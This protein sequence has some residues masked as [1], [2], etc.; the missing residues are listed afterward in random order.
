ML[1]S[2]ATSNEEEDVT[3]EAAAQGATKSSDGDVAAQVL[4]ALRSALGDER[5]GPD[6][7]FF[8]EGGDSVA[9]VQALQLIHQ[10]T[11]VQLAVAVFFT[12]A[13][14]GQLAEL[15]TGAGAAAGETAA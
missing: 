6:D 4:S 15:V 9:A 1:S 14:A 12:H 3:N 13:S 8:A 10:T 5:L 11:G 7:D 2:H